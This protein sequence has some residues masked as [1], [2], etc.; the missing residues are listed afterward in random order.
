MRVMA[1]GYQRKLA[2]SS[3]YPIILSLGASQRSL[4]SGGPHIAQ[5]PAPLPFLP[6]LSSIRRK[7][8]TTLQSALQRE[9][10]TLLRKKRC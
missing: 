7:A 10:H 6:E 4:E 2:N 5:K 8:Y 1:M 9:E 3:C